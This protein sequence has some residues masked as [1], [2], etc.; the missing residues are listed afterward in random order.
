M[1]AAACSA[2]PSTVA[3]I[4]N[5]HATGYTGT[6]LAP[7]VARPDLTLADI[8]GGDYSLAH[9]PTTELTVLFFGSTHCPECRYLRSTWL[10]ERG[11]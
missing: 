2:E 9:R 8:N 10:A 4:S 7:P 5:D 1:T 6:L 3:E 11:G